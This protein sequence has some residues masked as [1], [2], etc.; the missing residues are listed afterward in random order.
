LLDFLLGLF[1]HIFG[2]VLVAGD[3]GL[4]Y[5]TVTL[6]SCS[7]M[8]TQAVVCPEHLHIRPGVAQFSG[9]LF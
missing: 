4:D 2:S 6:Y 1:V 8:C 5:G 3:E 7:A 9:M